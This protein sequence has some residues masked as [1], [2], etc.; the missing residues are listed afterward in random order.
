MKAQMIKS[1]GGPEVFELSEI[2]APT[3]GPGQVLVKI[4]ASSVNTPASVA[5]TNSPT[6]WPT[7]PAGWTPHDISRRAS[8]YSITKT[9]GWVNLVW[10]SCAAALST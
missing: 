9:A 8:A 10:A 2:E 7:M 1:N 6:L 4:A 5:A 3:A